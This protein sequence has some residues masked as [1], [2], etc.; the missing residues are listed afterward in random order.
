MCRIN[1]NTTHVQIFLVKPGH[2][3]HEVAA[4]FF[5]DRCDG[6]HDFRNEL[7]EPTVGKELM[8]TKDFVKKLKNNKQL[9]DYSL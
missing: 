7:Q 6:A 4:E 3:E 2:K 8:H 1:R 5:A 9:S